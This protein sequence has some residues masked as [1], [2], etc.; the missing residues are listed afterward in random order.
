MSQTLTEL[1][2]LLIPFVTRVT[3]IFLSVIYTGIIKGVFISFCI[4]KSYALF[5][6]Y[7]FN[8]KK[9][10]GI[11]K[12]F[13]SRKHKHRYQVIATMTLNN[14]DITTTFNYVK[15]QYIDKYSKF[16]QILVKK[17]YE[18]WW[19]PLSPAEESAMN[20]SPPI[21]VHTRIHNHK[22]LIAYIQKEVNTYIDVFTT[23]PYEFTLIPYGNVA[24]NKG[25]VMLKYD[26]TLTDGLGIVAATCAS[27]SN[28]NV[29]IFPRLMRNIKD[30]K[31]YMNILSWL[32]YPYYVV[33][34]AL[35]MLQFFPYDSPFI[36]K[37]VTSVTKLAE[38]EKTYYLKDFENF[39]KQKQLS[40]NEL[41]MGV[42]SLAIYKMIYENKQHKYKGFEY[43]GKQ[44]RIMFPF[45]RKKLPEKAEMVNLEN[46]ANALFVKVPLI[47][48][49]N[50]TN[51]KAIQ[52]IIKEM[53]S[54]QIKYSYHKTA[55]ALGEIGTYPLVN[56]CT[57]FVCKRLDMA[58]TNV[59]GPTVKISYGKSECEEMKCYISA[60]YGFSFVPLLSYD[61]KFS[62]SFSADE[63]CEVD[64]KEFI[65]YI[66]EAM[67]DLMVLKDKM[68]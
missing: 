18:Y 32:M 20:T 64:P 50:D 8:L 63:G 51:F 35:F 6:Y 31:W 30:D 23:V 43:K 10:T 59:P 33:R 12:I 48:E 21:K 11:D 67:E 19:R 5:M 62:F 22:E 46:L 60:G 29:N 44:I 39:R 26:H 34:S 41:M 36:P 40:F 13:L 58:F 25:I 4:F 14:F 47:S 7:M 56:W 1:S 57:Q 54:Q 9:L 49:L 3:I 27:A 38:T 61:G 65:M 66:D 24:D 15:S 42:L 68:E 2:E 52:R 28:Y 55:F 37:N 53:F 17:L 16:K 45:G